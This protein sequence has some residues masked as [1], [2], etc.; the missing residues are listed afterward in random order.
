MARLLKPSCLA[1]TVVLFVSLVG[2]GGHS[3]NQPPAA[4]GLGQVHITITWPPRTEVDTQLIPARSNCIAITI[5]ADGPLTKR[6]LV[7]R[8]HRTALDDQYNSGLCTCRRRRS[9]H[10]RGLSQ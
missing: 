4:V 2:C 6:A 8:P 3:T 7:V 1:L 10:R 5:T 9:H